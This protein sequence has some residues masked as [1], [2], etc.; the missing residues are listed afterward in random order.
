[1][2][3]VM[4][5]TGKPQNFTRNGRLMTVYVL[6]CCGTHMNQASLLLQVGM[7]LSSTGTEVVILDK[8]GRSELFCK[9]D[10]LHLSFMV[11][12]MMRLK[13]PGLHKCKSKVNCFFVTDLS[14]ILDSCISLLPGG[15]RINCAIASRKYVFYI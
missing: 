9:Y 7:V 10:M 1:M 11:K 12:R 13:K 15:R 2:A 3:S 4:C 8:K 14:I 6:E 5:G